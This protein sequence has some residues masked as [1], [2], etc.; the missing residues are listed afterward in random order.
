MVL[1][2]SIKTEKISSA[3]DI[4]KMILVWPPSGTSLQHH[5]AKDATIKRLAQRQ[6]CK[7]VTRSRS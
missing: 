2:R 5:M 1:L 6:V 3:S 4:I 7:T